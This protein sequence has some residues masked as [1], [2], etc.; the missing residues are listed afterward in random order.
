MLTNSRFSDI[1]MVVLVV[2]QEK[3]EISVHENVLF[4]ASPVFK[5]AFAP[6]FK[7]PSERSIIFQKTVLFSWTR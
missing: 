5:A 7:E 2:G 1:E 4:D 3:T 6:A